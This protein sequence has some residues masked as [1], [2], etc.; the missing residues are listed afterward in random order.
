MEK[1]QWTVG[2]NVVA[3][4]GISDPDTGRDIGGWQGRISEIFEEE[5]SGH[6]AANCGTG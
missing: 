5:G 1:Q 2:E 3:K 4:P 6:S